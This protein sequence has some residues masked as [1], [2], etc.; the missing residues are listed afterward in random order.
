M[1]ATGPPSGDVPPP[2]GGA[3][4]GHD[5]EPGALMVYLPG[6]YLMCA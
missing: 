4:Q 3:W 2:T 6:W 1:A 5:G